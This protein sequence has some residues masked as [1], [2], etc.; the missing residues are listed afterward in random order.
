MKIPSIDWVQVRARPRVNYRAE[1]I[2]HIVEPC[3][4]GKIVSQ[5]LTRYMK[6]SEALA[7]MRIMLKDNSEKMIKAMLPIAMKMKS[8]KARMILYKFSAKMCINAK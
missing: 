6:M 3:Y 1:I 4:R 5:N 7:F 8:R 2:R